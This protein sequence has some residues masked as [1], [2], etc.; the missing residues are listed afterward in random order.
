MAMR[1]ANNRVSLCA[2]F[3][4]ICMFIFT[5]P[6]CGKSYRTAEVDGMLVIHDQPGSKVR[7][8]FVPDASKATQGPVS[9][10]ETDARG[11]FTLSLNEGDLA[12]AQ[13][14]AVVG[15]HRVVLTD[16]R[17]SESDTGAGIP[18]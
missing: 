12:A 11:H 15:W 2:D 9:V 4:A 18:I 1:P 8:Q 13:P 14:G 5:L 3:M 10:A 16:L 17:L 6:G 7:I